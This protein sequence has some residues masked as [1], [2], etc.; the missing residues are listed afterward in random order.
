[1]TRGRL[2]LLAALGIDNFGSGL[3]LPLTLIYLTHVVQLPLAVAGSA[4]TAGTLAGLLAP[5]LAGRLVD[6]IGPR[7]VV[8]I[9]QLVQAIG[10]C[11]YLLA[12][13]VPMVVAA[14][15][16]IAGGL[17]LFYCSLFVLVADVSSEVLKD[18][19]FAVV[20]MVRAGSFG[21]GALV[22]G[23]LLTAWGPAGYQV[24]LVTNA[25]TLVIAALL[26]GIGVST[27][28]PSPAPESGIRRPTGLLRDRPYLAL[29]VVSSLF[30]LSLDFFL[31]GMPV[32]VLDQLGGPSWLPGAILALLTT[33]TSFGSTAALRLT[34][35][36]TRIGAMSLGSALYA[37]WCVVSLAAVA[38]PAPWLPAYLLTVTLVMAAANLVFGP[39][40]NAL[41]EAAAP[42]AARG[43]YLASYQYA[44]AS[45]QIV[46]PAVVALFSVAIWLPWVVVAAA[47]VAA[48]VGLRALA[49]RLP[50]HAVDP[51]T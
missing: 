43:R 16:L 45:A 13:G 31:V 8:I 44:F 7:A 12:D 10:A 18:R 32:F 19:P 11:C 20:T 6:L 25:V 21:L 24:A 38:V 9:S 51:R 2:T 14:A 36:L 41:A 49:P 40:S 3:F 48:S 22:A 34:R 28:R 37:V 26:L 29:I 1:M 39:R 5:P 15:L 47:A 27:P 4:V 17:Q 30:G 35:H 23:A 50:P 33:V 46:A 42:R